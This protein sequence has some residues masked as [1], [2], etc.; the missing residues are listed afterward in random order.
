[1]T[2]AIYDRAGDQLG[3]FLPRLGGALALLVVGLLVAIVIGRLVRSALMRVGVDRFAQRSGTQDLLAS[4]GLGESLA[5]LV[6]TAVRLSIV[7]VVVFASLTLLG[8]EFLSDSLNA[9]ILYIP[10]LIVAL[11]LL[12]IGLVLGAF[13]RAWVERTSA[14]VDFPVAI[15][16]VVLCAA[17]QAGVATGP[18]TALALLLLG[19]VA[20]T[21]AVAFGLGSR[22]VARSLSSGRY[23]RADFEVGQTIRIDDLRGTIVRM[24]GAATTLRSGQDT[25]RV[26]NHL[27]V[28]R[29][30]VVEAESM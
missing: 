7:I 4:A 23:V 22:E 24:D 18:L 16:P 8:F 9:G 25:V 17:A 27:L 12:L 30:V 13:V 11:G 29:V 28:E 21:L 15:G 6:G 2:A 5:R 3:E 1:M 10:R 14:Q 19:A 26:P 20:V